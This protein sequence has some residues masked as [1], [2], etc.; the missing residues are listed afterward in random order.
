LGF[1]RR[2]T[3]RANIDQPPWIDKRAKRGNF[4][5]ADLVQET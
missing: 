2:A 5:W 4:R 3:L 1:K